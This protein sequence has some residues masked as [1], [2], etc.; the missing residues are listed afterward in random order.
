MARQDVHDQPSS[1]EP[2]AFIAQEGVDGLDGQ[3]IDDLDGEGAGCR[4]SIPPACLS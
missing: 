3:V 4:C 2:E 1:E